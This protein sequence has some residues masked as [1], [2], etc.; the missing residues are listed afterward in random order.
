MVYI[1]VYFIAYICFRLLAN[2]IVALSP[3][4]KK[5]KKTEIALS[6]K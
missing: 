3:E 4:K 2:S 1:S 5:K 6:L